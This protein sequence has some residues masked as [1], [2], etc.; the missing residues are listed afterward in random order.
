MTETK[1]S[2]WTSKG[3]IWVVIDRAVRHGWGATLRLV[4]LL[5][6]IMIG[7]CIVGT[8][9]AN[10]AGWIAGQAHNVVAL[11]PGPG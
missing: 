5:I 2:W 6:V 9:V 8:D 10:A 11:L 4:L 3:A 1:Q 7:G